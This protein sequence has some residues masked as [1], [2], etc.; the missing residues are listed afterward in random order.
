MSKSDIDVEILVV[1]LLNYFFTSPRLTYDCQAPP[2][3]PFDV[4]IGPM[5]TEEGAPNVVSIRTVKSDVVVGVPEDVAKRL[6]TEEEGWRISGKYAVI[7]LSEAKK[8]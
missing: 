2:S 3:T 7:S 5:S 1:W 6:D 4:A 8:Q